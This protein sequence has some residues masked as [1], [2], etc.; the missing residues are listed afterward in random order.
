MSII[1]LL[2]V[3]FLAWCY[4]EKKRQDKIVEKLYQR[5][6]AKV[7]LE[8]E[9]QLFTDIP[10]ELNINDLFKDINNDL[11]SPVSSAEMAVVPAPDTIPII[12]AEQKAPSYQTMPSK[13][14]DRQ[15][16]NGMNPTPVIPSN[17]ANNY[18]DVTNFNPNSFMLL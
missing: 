17:S 12:Q 4:V 18:M 11:N 16:L 10:A 1:L 15:M 2:L 7:M 9:L 8:E 6:M 3:L 14:R 5:K 13:K